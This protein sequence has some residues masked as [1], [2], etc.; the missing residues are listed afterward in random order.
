MQ[1]DVAA[2]LAYDAWRREGST[3]YR[4][5]RR[6][7]GG[8]T[9]SWEPPVIPDG[10]I[11]TTDPDSRMMRSRGTT[12][13]GYNAQA[14]VTDA[15]DHRSGQAEITLDAAGLRATSSRCA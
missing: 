3:V 5:S 10:R 14:A 7:P 15:A 8:P 2:N 4:G 6:S 9:N 13:Q 11:N 12:I 1:V